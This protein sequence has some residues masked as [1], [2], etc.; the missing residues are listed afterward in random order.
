M[1]GPFSRCGDDDP[2]MI[3]PMPRY[4]D[5]GVDAY[6]T[7]DL[8]LTDT[9]GP[10][11]TSQDDFWVDP[12]GRT[13][14]ADKD[15]GGGGMTCVFVTNKKAG[16]C[17]ESCD[18]KA[19][20]VPTCPYKT[21]CAAAPA[22]M[23]SKTDFCYRECTLAPG[24]SGC[25]A[26]VACHF[27]MLVGEPA[28][29]LC[30]GPPSC[31]KDSDCVVRTA[32][33]CDVSA[34]NKCPTGQ[35]CQPINSAASSAGRCGKPG[36]CDVKSGL[37]VGHTAGNSKAKV[38]DVCT[39][40]TACGGE[41][42]CLMERDD[43]LHAL[44]GGKACFQD[45][46]CCSG[47][48]VGGKCT[49]G[50][51][52]TRNRNGYCTVVGCAHKAWTARACPSG[53]VCSQIRLGG[54]CLLGCDLSQAAQCRGHAKDLLGD[55]ECRAWNNLVLSGVSMA[56]GAVCEPGPDMACNMLTTSSLDCSAVGVAST[57]T[58]NMSCRGLDN[59][60]LAVGSAK[61][62]CLDDTASGTGER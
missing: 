14:A 3:P 17:A 60:M 47:R 43:K 40:D 12:T 32:A 16:V 55:Y 18:R 4:L 50:S 46:E 41:M 13:C 58:T 24:Q 25:P 51:C 29:G 8:R 37:C 54:R 5:A 22:G 19:P 31:T 35:V 39:D 9:R 30:L 44:G 27:G 10:D 61:G 57:N 20:L 6:V 38:G 42:T 53:S 1:S 7:P 21:A 49:A 33:T 56:S 2:P 34:P 15:C 28:Q 11:L 45:S 48:C 23:S 52:V 62:Y 59:A 26:G 36:K